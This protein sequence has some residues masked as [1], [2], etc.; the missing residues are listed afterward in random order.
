MRSSIEQQEPYLSGIFA[1]TCVHHELEFDS[2]RHVQR[3]LDERSFGLIIAACVSLPMYPRVCEAGYAPRFPQT[4]SNEADSVLAC[5]Q[6][7][8]VTWLSHA[9]PA[10]N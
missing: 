4:G 5:I 1:V 8:S 2:Y 3:V 10:R 6:K 7:V 9:A